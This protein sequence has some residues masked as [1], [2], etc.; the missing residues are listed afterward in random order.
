[1]VL[2]TTRRAAALLLAV[3]A[4]LL[5]ALLAAPSP[6]QASVLG[7]KGVQ[8]GQGWVD[9]NA[10]GRADYCRLTDAPVCTLSTGTGFGQSWSGPG[11]DLGYTAGRAWT[12][13]NGDGRADYCRVV[14]GVYQSVQCTI[15]TAD[16]FGATYGSNTIDAGYDAGRAWVDINN[17]NRADYCRVVGGYQLACL[18][19]TGAG[20]EPT[21]ITSGS[22]DPG[23]DAGRTWTDINNDNRADYCRIVGGS[24]KYAQCTPSTGTGFGLAVSSNA[25]DPGYDDSRRWADINND[26]RADFCRIVGLWSYSIT[27]TVSNGASFGS[28]YSSGLD[29]GT[30]GTSVWADVNNDGRDDFCRKV[31]GTATC[32]LSQGTSFSGHLSANTS[33]WD[34]VGFAD[35][36]G[37]GGADFCHV[38]SGVPSCTVSNGGSFGT[39]YGP[40]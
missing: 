1:M 34:T 14:G 35:F 28:T 17:D 11:L 26:K 24:N 22:I 19:S 37:S 30:A 2:T 10:D 21:S 13:F 36:N 3:A 39:R 18:R 27:C 12:D 8:A 7:F 20:F 5:A 4:A 31:G 29:T 9:F 40:L 38:V 25:L 32:T 33:N 23:Y 15:S 16:G 6:A